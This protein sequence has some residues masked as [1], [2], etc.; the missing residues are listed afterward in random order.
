[1]KRTRLL[2]VLAALGL[3]ASALGM[4]SAN[5]SAA[6]PSLAKQAAQQLRSD[7]AHHKEITIPVRLAAHRSERPDAASKCASGDGVEVCFGITGSGLV[8]GSMMGGYRNLSRGSFAAFDAIWGPD[9][10]E[11]QTSDPTI[12]NGIALNIG[13]QQSTD[14]AGGNYCTGGFWVHGSEATQIGPT[15][16][17]DVF[18]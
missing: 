3:A 1:M 5:A 4:T 9:G 10:F 16:C 18:E 6:T 17:I 11:I 12:A 14:S 13:W 15:V 8:L 2:A 7:V